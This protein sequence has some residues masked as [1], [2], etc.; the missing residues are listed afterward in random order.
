MI[1]PCLNTEHAGICS[2]TAAPHA[3]SIER[4]ERFCF[5]DGFES[6]A[7]YQQQL[8][9]PAAAEVVPVFAGDTADVGR[10]GSA[11]PAA[12]QGRTRRGAL[13][14]KRR[15][16]RRHSL[17]PARPGKRSAGFDAVLSA[18]LPAPQVVG[19]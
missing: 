2:G 10:P 3:P 16:Q 18:V 6:C 14:Q 17:F 12:T 9:L 4:M 19:R 7:I 1:C 5:R 11:G 8:G 13:R 15:T